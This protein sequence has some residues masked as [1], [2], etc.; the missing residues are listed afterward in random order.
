M[1]IHR[2]K[3]DVEFV[4]DLPTSRASQQVV[5]AVVALADGFGLDTVA[6]GVEDQRSRELLEEYGI[7]YLQGFHLG[8]QGPLGKV[9]FRPDPSTGWSPPGGKS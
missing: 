2:L 4:K 5:K 7:D 1:P 9:L 3:I 8:R 6:E